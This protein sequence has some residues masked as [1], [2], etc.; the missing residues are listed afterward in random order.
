MPAS[1]RKQ[2]EK[3]EFGGPPT[4]QSTDTERTT[5]VQPTDTV[6]PP[7]VQ[8]ETPRRQIRIPNGDWLRLKREAAE[9][10]ISTSALIRMIVREWLSR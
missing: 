10:G 3:R 6:H 2:F 8:G 4:A 7:A 5:D 1:K 9:R